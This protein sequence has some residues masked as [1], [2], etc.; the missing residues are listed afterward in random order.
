MSII[1]NS[2]KLLQTSSRIDLFEIDYMRL[3][4]TKSIV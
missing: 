4:A 3:G 1:G 2:E